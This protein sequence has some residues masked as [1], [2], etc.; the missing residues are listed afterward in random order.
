MRVDGCTQTLVSLN[1]NHF[2]QYAIRTTTFKTLP[3][4]IRSSSHRVGI[5]NRLQ[6][7]YAHRA[8]PTVNFVSLHCNY[9]AHPTV[10]F[11]VQIPP[12]C[13]VT[14]VLVPFC[15]FLAGS[16]GDHFLR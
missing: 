10:Q 12:R 9:S 7:S 1:Y 14:G 3:Y 8:T 2:P 4:V 13:S 15:C 5:N 16:H 11:H 6:V